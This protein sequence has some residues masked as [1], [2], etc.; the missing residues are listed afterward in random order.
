V[1]A[2]GTRALH[3]GS[4]AAASA[5]EPAHAPQAADEPA[6]DFDL[7]DDQRQFMHVAETFAREELA[8]YRWARNL[9]P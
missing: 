6:A 9:P 5:A 8:P 2:A 3:W 7:T 1:A 4:A